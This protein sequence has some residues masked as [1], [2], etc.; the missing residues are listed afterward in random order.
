MYR[1]LIGHLQ[2][3]KIH[4]IEVTIANLSQSLDFMVCIRQYCNILYWYFNILY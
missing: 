2:A 4:W 3:I 1:P